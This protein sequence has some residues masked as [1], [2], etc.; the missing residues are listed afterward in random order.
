MYIFLLIQKIKLENEETLVADKVYTRIDRTKSHL[1]TR[2]NQ[3]KPKTA[4]IQQALEHLH[5][6]DL[7]NA[8]KLKHHLNKILSKRLRL[9]K[10]Q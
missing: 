8:K 7:K 4:L 1:E 10:E 3:H 2:I 6:F 9:R 5:F